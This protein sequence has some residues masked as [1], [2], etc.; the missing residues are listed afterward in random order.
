LDNGLY[1]IDKPSDYFNTVLYTGTGLAGQAQTGVG[2]Q[3]DLV[4]TKSRSNTYPHQWY[5]VIR[6]VTQRLQSNDISAEATQSNGLTAFGTDG[7]TVGDASGTG[8]SGATY[9]SWNWKADNTSGS[10]NT[11]GSITSY[12]FSKHYKWIFSYNFYWRW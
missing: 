11:D 9:A 7:F 8:V 10:S 6:G 4:W 12:S 3:P 1:N 5:D 2:F